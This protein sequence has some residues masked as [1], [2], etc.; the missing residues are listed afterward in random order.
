MGPREPSGSAPGEALV[1][2]SRIWA[3]LTVALLVGAPPSLLPA[4]AARLLVPLIDL[5][6]RVA[7]DSLDP[8]VH[9]DVAL[10]YW[11]AKRFD[12]AERS[13]RRAVVIEPDLA[14]AYLA[15]AYLPFARRPKLWKEEDDSKVPAAWADRLEESDR[16]FRR[17][18]LI[19]PMVDLK[20]Y[21]LV[22]P[23][24]G[25]IV[26]GRNASVTYAALIRGFESFWDGQY[27]TSYNWLE[28][29]L[30][31]V[32]RGKNEDVPHA[33]L[34]YHGLAAAH[35]GQFD[36]AIVDFQRLFDRAIA[37]EQTDSLVRGF[38][39]KSNQIRYILATISHK[40]GRADQ[41]LALFEE[42]LANDLSL[43]MGHVQMAEIYEERREWEAAISERRRAV[44]TSPEDPSLQY[45][46][47]YTLA[48]ALRFPDAAE[49]LA[50]AMRANPNNARI[51]YTLGLV[52]LRLGDRE[53]AREALRR[54]VAI[55]PSRFS[56]QVVEARQQLALLEQ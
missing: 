13:L 2:L 54:F 39:L 35:T 30:R 18:F 49:A 29:V 19:D 10:G 31:K 51:P 21:G 24:R 32:D 16:L 25:A 40:A 14:P 37:R 38:T 47:G 36:V 46:L 44:E 11:V 4:Q 42:S 28:E 45:E 41:A 17:A 12:D 15:L 1:S 34:W 20:V 7:R 9:Y 48:R 33:L 56:D 53:G 50:G 8:L 22:V 26:I 5:E 52:Y 3:Y 43:Y 6:A 23:P 55:A 27:A